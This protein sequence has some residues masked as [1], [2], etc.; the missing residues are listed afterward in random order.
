MSD[1]SGNLLLK[2]SGMSKSFVSA[3]GRHNFNSHNAQNPQNAEGRTLFNDLNFELCR[4]EVLAIEGRSGSGKSTLLHCLVGLA[5]PDQGQVVINGNIIPLEDDDYCSR[6]RLTTVGLVFQFFNLLPALTLAQNIILP[7][8]LL[9]VSRKVALDKAQS[10]CQELG[11]SHCAH[12]LPGSVSG[13]EAQRAAVARALINDPQIILADEPT[14]NLDANNGEQLM[15][16][17]VTATE[18][19]GCGVILVTHDRETVQRATRTLM[20]SN[21]QL[22][23]GQ[24]A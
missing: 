6:L 22:S 3:A 8:Q 20:L 5:R 19:R 17:L 16:V 10:L 9:G 12:R 1:Y 14:G 23:S 11:I 7:A 21:G 18:S 13:G 24:V 4:G 2:A 15:D